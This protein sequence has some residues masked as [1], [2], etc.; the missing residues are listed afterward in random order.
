MRDTKFMISWLVDPH[1]DHISTR[2][3][4]RQKPHEADGDAAVRRLLVALLLVG[5]LSGCGLPGGQLVTECFDTSGP[6]PCPS[7][8]PLPFDSN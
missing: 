1:P 7:M 6:I 2:H 8:L 4:E 5:G 3:V